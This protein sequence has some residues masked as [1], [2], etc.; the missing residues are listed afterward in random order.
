VHGKILTKTVIELQ[1]RQ[2]KVAPQ[3]QYV[4]SQPQSLQEYIPNKSHLQNQYVATQPQYI[5]NQPVSQ[6]IRIAPQ[7]QSPNL[8]EGRSEPSNNRKMY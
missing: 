7:P 5:P 8:Q 6:P 4:P 2:I 1:S 3:Q